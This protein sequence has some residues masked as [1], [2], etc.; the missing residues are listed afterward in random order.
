MSRISLQRR[1]TYNYNTFSLCISYAL[2]IHY[3]VNYTSLDHRVKNLVVSL[4]F[5]STLLV[6]VLNTYFNNLRLFSSHYSIFEII[7]FSYPKTVEYEH[8]VIQFYAKQT[9]E[10]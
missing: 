9:I 10:S 8:F 3:H 5:I 6:T 2:Y 4:L 1:C 7:D